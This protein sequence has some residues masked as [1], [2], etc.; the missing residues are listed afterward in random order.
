MAR[1]AAR[2][3]AMRLLYGQSF[4][5][6]GEGADLTEMM[7][8]HRL[9]EK[10]AAYIQEV[11]EGCRAHLPEMD[12]IIRE[13]AKGWRF[14]RLSRVDLS[15]LRLALYEILYRP[16][17]PASVSVHEGVEL[18]KKYSNEKSGAFVNGVLGTYLRDSGLVKE[19]DSE[20][21]ETPGPCS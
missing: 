2:E 4:Q 14:D 9:D 8:E 7:S 21:S 17:I 6:Q 19:A 11:L 16:D 18:A 10:D 5:A 15:V 3:A 20:P 1:R 12:R 13:R